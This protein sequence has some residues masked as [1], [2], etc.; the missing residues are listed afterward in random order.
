MQDRA[1]LD[2]G[3]NPQLKAHRRVPVTV[4]V[5][6]DAKS[7]AASQSQD[8]ESTNLGPPI[9]DNLPL[10]LFTVWV[11]GDAARARLSFVDG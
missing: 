10:Q 3:G 4:W 2:S 1:L 7:S 5:N 6:G 11:N 9:G 8:Q